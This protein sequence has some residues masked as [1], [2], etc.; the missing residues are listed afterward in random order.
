LAQIQGLVHFQRGLFRITEFDLVLAKS[1]LYKALLFEEQIPAK[2]RNRI[3][4]NLANILYYQN[5]YAEALSYCLKQRD[6][7]EQENDWLEFRLPLG[8]MQQK[9][10]P[11]VP[12][13][14]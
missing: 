7:A 4:N 1:G 11:G 8:R 14:S 13:L 10:L 6:L 12:V 2:Q 3:Y 9:K 5:D